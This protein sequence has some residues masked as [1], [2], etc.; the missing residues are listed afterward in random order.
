MAAATPPSA[1]TVWA[2]PSSDLQTSPTSAPASLAAIAARRPA[3]PAPMTRTSWGRTCGLIG[4]ERTIRS[5]LEVDR[6]VGDDPHRQQADI[7]IGKRDG[8]QARPRPAHVEQVHQR[9]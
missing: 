9:G 3:P 7:Q 8:D 5:R 4:A 2:L 6:R 1:I